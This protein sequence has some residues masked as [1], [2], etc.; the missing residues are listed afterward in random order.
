MIRYSLLLLWGLAVRQNWRC[1]LT[2]IIA[3]LVL[4]ASGFSSD[5]S[6]IDSK[7]P[8]EIRRLKSQDFANPATTVIFLP[9]AGDTSN[10]R[11]RALVLLRFKLDGLGEPSEVS[12]VVCT[13]PNRGLEVIAADTVK[14]SRFTNS[15]KRN[16]RRGWFYHVVE[17]AEPG[18]DEDVL[19][20]PP[21]FGDFLPDEEDPKMI[22][23][24]APQYPAGAK[25]TGASGLVEVEALV[26]RGGIVRQVEINRH[27]GSPTLDSAAVTAAYHNRYRPGMKRGRPTACWVKYE[28]DFRLTDSAEATPPFTSSELP[29]PEEFVPVDIYPEMIYHQIPEY[30]RIAKENDLTGLI[31]IKAL[32]DAKGKVREAVV[33]KS[34]GHPELDESA[35]AAAMLCRF[36]PAYHGGRAV[37]VWVTWKVEFKLDR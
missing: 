9:I 18:D 8:N 36:K 30:P 34:C 23:Q 4:R 10:I 32:V 25:T 35:R 27:S 22:F 28:V 37:A 26:D 33:A 7:I 13:G 14:K 20:D 2:S 12:T 19:G 6:V 3:C 1:I 29:A 21:P 11:E 17:F 15:A 5:D 31:W 24:E 16:G